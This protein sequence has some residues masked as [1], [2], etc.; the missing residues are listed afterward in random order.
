MLRILS[1]RLF[2]LAPSYRD[3]RLS[4]PPPSPEHRPALRPSRSPPSSHRPFFGQLK[5]ANRPAPLL[6]RTFNSPANPWHS[7]QPRGTRKLHRSSGSPREH[8]Q[9]M[10]QR[11]H[12]RPTR[13]LCCHH[14]QGIGVPPHVHSPFTATTVTAYTI[15]R[16]VTSPCFT[17]SDTADQAGQPSDGRRPTAR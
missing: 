14:R 16:S 6:S 3:A 7:P 15:P 1:T 17:S 12:D 5:A 8:V 10:H 2:L 13:A 11:C 4:L 9:Y